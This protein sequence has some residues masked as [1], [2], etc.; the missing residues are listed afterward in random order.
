MTTFQ[1][2]DLCYL[3]RMKE[4][5]LIINVNINSLTLNLG[6]LKGKVKAIQQNLITQI[7]FLVFLLL[8]AY[9]VIQNHRGTCHDQLEGTPIF[10]IFTALSA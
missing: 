8:K 2:Q 7:R 9:F 3:Y 6:G 1:L 10:P 4:D 5:G